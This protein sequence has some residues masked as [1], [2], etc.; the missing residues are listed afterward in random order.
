MVSHF[1]QLELKDKGEWYCD[2]DP[3]EKKVGSGGGTASVLASAFKAD[4][5]AGTFSDWL[6][7]KKRMVIHSGGESRRL[8]AYAPYGKSLLPMPVFR[9]S[10]GQYIDQK[11]LDFQVSY[12]D[13]I[14]KNAPD[15]YTTL[16]GSGDVMFISGDRFNDL[17]EAD[18]LVFGIW[19]DD[20]VASRHGVFFSPRQ[21]QDQLAFVK[22]KPT[23]EA[24]GI[25]AKDYFYLMDSGIVLMNA[26]TT[27]K[28]MK[29]SGWDEKN[30][31][32]T[33]GY[34]EFYDLYGEMLTSFGSEASEPDPELAG[35]DVRLVPLNDGE[36]YHF[37]SNRDLIESSL[38][39][40]NRVTDQRLKFTRE[41]DH[42]PSIFQQNSMVGFRFSDHNHHL[43]IENA[44]IPFYMETQSPSH[45]YG[46]A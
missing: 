42:H 15:A 41:T 14:L 31:S 2:S 43:W 9:W 27:L 34:P 35:L 19:V 33:G 32:F 23:R 25:F 13:K 11:L 7:L 20:E 24:L 29:K 6:S 30:G 46:R 36:F 1:H 38:R 45:H 8:P 18:V 26:K 3:I 5:F 4:G 44:Y 22:Q 10:K 37:G 28:L 12:Y 40:Q 21:Q 16:V 39:L 17:P